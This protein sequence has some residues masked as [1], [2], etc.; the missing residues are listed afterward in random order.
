MEERERYAKAQK[1]AEELKEFYQHL[2][3]YV[4]V[5]TFLLVVNLLTS[6]GYLWVR[7]PIFGWGIGLALHAASVFGRTRFWGDKWQERKIK[8]LMDRDR[9]GL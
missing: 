4:L 6:P 7:W 2:V 1:R 8:E 3:A 5:N 9:D